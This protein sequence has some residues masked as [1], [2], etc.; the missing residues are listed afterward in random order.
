[1]PTLIQ[2]RRDTAST[3][4]S[5]N[6]TL[7][8]GEMG[9]ETDTGQF[10]I[11]NGSSSWTA[12]A[13]GGLGISGYSGYSGV[14]GYS[15]LSGY[16]GSGVSGYSGIGTSGYSGY[17][18]VSGYSGESTSGYSGYSGVSG[19]SGLSGYSGIGTSGYSGYSGAAGP[20]STINATDDT[21]TVADHYPVFVAAAGSNQTAEVSTT[22][23]YYRPSTG[24]LSATDFNTLS[25]IAY[26]E[27]IQPIQNA[28]NKILD[29]RGV[30]YKMKDTK[31]KSLGVIAQ[32]IENIL[33]ETVSKNTNG[34][35]TVSYNNIIA[36]LIE[37]IKE[38]KEEIDRLKK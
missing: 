20:S 13:Y 10:K 31:R 22:K 38:L 2:F 35:K 18:G 36:V 7:A 37:A 33:P 4:T 27:D 12:L 14:S 29:M 32:E 19:Y 15:G 8:V 11:G 28:L 1:M 9:L 25:D 23:L 16:S 30:S 24:Q 6:P 21:S 34:S 26:K 3:W 5:V 17:S